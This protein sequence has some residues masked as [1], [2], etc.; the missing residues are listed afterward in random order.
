MVRIP[1]RVAIIGGIAALALLAGGWWLLGPLFGSGESATIVFGATIPITGQTAKEGEYTRDGYT[2][3]IDTINAQGGFK[4]GDKRYKVKLQYYD[5]QSSPEL[6]AKLYEKLITEDKVNFL[7]G[8]YG[9]STSAAAA[10]VAEKYHVPILMAHGSAESVYSPN[11]R[12]TFG[13]VSPAKNYLRGI[14]AVVLARD[15]K[16]HTVA[17]LGSDEPFSYEVLSG[18]TEYAR[19]QNLDVVYT[20]FY[21]LNAS[22]VSQFLQDIKA[23]NPDI[24]L[25]AGR[26]QDSLLVVRQAQGVNL[27][28]RALGFTIGPSTPEFRN[29]LKADAD[30]IF[31]A[32]QWTSALQYKGD[33]PWE[34]PRA[35]ATAFKARHPGYEDVP[36]HV[37]ESSASLVAYQRALEKAGSLNLEAVRDA[38]ENLD[39]N[40]FYG[41]IKFDE[42][43]MNVY[44]PMAVEQLQPDG[45]RYTVF[46]FDV[47]EKQALYPMPP[48]NS[49]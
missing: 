18:T 48:W 34:T 43:G 13:V 25:V 39:I 42:R 2:F 27:A 33:D 44:K 45:K 9:S 3:Y 47:S 40:T 36:Y 26:L 4:I 20:S 1:A 11:G 41:R 22:D 35:F 6:S 5:D 46:P 10:V 23:K 29:N 32:T 15:P 14:I 12:Y 37:A 16:V 21:P 30:Y 31:G 24:V 28:P 49:R 17:L 38:L 7:I 19:S 8:P